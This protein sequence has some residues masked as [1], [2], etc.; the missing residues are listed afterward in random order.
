MSIAPPFECRMDADGTHRSTCSALTPSAR[1]V[2]TRTG[3]GTPDPYGVRLPHGSAI[4]SLR[5]TA[6]VPFHT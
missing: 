4:A 5:P 1:W 6:T 2:S 3:Q